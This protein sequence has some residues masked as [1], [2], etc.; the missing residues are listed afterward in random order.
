MFEAALPDVTDASRNSV[1]ILRLRGRS[2]LGTTFMDVLRRYA[3]RARRAIDSKLV[4]VSTSE[5]IIEQLAVTGITE[6]IGP[7]SIYPGDERVGAA[8]RRAHQDA[9]AWIERS[10]P[11]RVTGRGRPNWLVADRPA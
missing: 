8:L 2:D 1:V 4:I 3:E 5:R 9:L 7:E 6:I 10:Q 11:H